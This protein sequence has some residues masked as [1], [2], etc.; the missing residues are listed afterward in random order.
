MITEYANGNALI[1]ENRDF[2][3]TNPDLA[4]FFFLDAPH[5]TEADRV[6]YAIRVTEGEDILLALKVEPYPFLLFGSDVLTGALAA[7][8]MD[9]GYEIKAILGGETACD[10]FTEVLRER[11][12]RPYTEALAMD[13]MRAYKKTEPS[14]QAVEIP[15]V[16]DLDE[17][18]ECQENF[19]NDCGTTGTVSREKIAEM[20][21]R[22]RILRQD[23]RIVS[24]ARCM[25]HSDAAMR[26]GFV[27]TRP[28]YR[29]HGLARQVVNTLK[30]EILDK[31]LTP[32]L[33]VDKKNPVSNHLYTSLGFER[34]FSQGEY[35]PMEATS[36]VRA[37]KADAPALE[38]ETGSS[39]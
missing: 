39:V 15:T 23:G 3:N 9:N 35:H 17:L 26:I 30:N 5:L 24:M 29:G 36:I 4:V 6:N 13:F 12:G 27:Y 25:P 21:D 31:G 2:L 14:S 38:K 32:T 22:F 34:A 28:E 33:N 19:I 37:G 20:L 1:E 7:H 18:V 10:R 11:Y 8:L 16:A